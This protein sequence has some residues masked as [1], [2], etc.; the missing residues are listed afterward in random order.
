ESTTFT[1]K[2]AVGDV[3]FGRRRAYLKKAAQASF[4]GICSGDITVFRTKGELSPT[5]L[6]FIV[7]NER[8]IDYAIQHSAGGLSPRVK[9]KDLANYEFLLPPQAQQSEL[10]ELLWAM[11]EVIEKASKVHE[12]LDQLFKVKAK[13]ISN[14]SYKES[15]LYRIKELCN[16]KDNLRVP[17]NSKQREKMVGDIPYYGAN[18]RVGNVNKSIFDEDLVLLAEDGGNFSEF[19]AKEIA[20]KVSGESWV[21]NHAHVLSMKDSS[22]SIDWLHFSLIH[23]NITKHIIGTTRVKLNKSDLENIKIWVPPEDIRIPVEKEMLILTQNRQLAK[24]KLVSSEGFNKSI[25]NQVFS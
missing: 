18:G 20:Y 24:A 16:I 21:N 4:A 7:Q 17:L 1:K 9:F 14:L 23:K 6:P 13:L 22:C 15:E 11:D 2:F 19:Y 8:F 5:L 25:I 10:A 12:R 3:L